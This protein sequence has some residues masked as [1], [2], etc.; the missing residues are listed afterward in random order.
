M[1]DKTISRSLPEVLDQLE[2]ALA[3][4]PVL[5]SSRNI[6]G[7]LDRRLVQV[8]A[9]LASRTPPREARQPRAQPRTDTLPLFF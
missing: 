6:I 3:A 8:R 4:L 1:R 9:R 5:Q 7:D 2:Q